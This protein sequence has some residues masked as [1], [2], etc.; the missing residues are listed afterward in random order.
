MTRAP[1]FLLLCA[2]CSVQA[3]PHLAPDLLA[4]YDSS[5]ASCHETGAAD[6]PRTG[7]AHEWA[8]RTRRG[9]PALVAA[10]KHGTTAMPPGGLCTSCDD[11]HLQALV[12]YMATPR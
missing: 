7:E 5:C 9:V 2:A 4:K 11:T 10:V 1:L 8:H 6:A 12:E 3:S